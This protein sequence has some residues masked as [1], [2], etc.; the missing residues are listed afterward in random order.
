ME[1][2]NNEQNINK[3][4][5]KVKYIIYTIIIVLLIGTVVMAGLLIVK[6]DTNTNIGSVVDEK[7]GKSNK[8]D[9]GKDIQE[10]ENNKDKKG[11]MSLIASRDQVKVGDEIVVSVVMNTEDMNISAA[12]AFVIFDQ[13]KLV[14]KSVELGDSV[15]EFGVEG[16]AF[17]EQGLVRIVRGQP[18]DSNPSD[19]DD[20]YT[21]SD[22]VL[23][24]VVFEAKA[25][26]DSDINFDESESKMIYDNGLGT[27]MNSIYKNLNI[28]IQ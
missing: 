12:S 28:S 10:N 4:N 21:G 7:D 8:V 22:G 14:A 15:M 3:K 11:I 17:N 9:D 6:K 5:N 26:G 23:A 27:A 24:K 18:G 19:N 20:G 1:E 13:N 16:K 2:L 25:I